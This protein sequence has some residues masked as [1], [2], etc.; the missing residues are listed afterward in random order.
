MSLKA[1]TPRG[2]HAH[3]QLSQ[4]LIIL[5]G[6]IS[7]TL[8]NLTVEADFGLSAGENILIE[9]GVWREFVSKEQGASLL[10]LASENYNEDDYIRNYEDF[11]K[12]KNAIL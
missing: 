6:T 10:V 9:P 8:D 4:L 12:W 11:R 7:L 1:N 3:K 5:T 2:F